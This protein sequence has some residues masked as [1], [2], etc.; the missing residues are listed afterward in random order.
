MFFFLNFLNHFEIYILHIVNLC[1][2]LFDVSRVFSCP[3]DDV[4][5]VYLHL[6]TKGMVQP[7]LY[8][9]ILIGQKA[10]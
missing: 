4:F 10:I 3:C 2:L 5:S 1:L 7:L 8:G 9:K 6:P